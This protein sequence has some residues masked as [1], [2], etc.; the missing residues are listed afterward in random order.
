[1]YFKTVKFTRIHS[2]KYKKTVESRFI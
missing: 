2:F 1:M